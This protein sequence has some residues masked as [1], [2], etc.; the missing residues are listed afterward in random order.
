MPDP[1]M[2]MKKSQIPV[3]VCG[4][5]FHPRRGEAMTTTYLTGTYE[6]TLSLLAETRALLSR[7]PD[8]GRG[9]VGQLRLVREAMRITSRLSQVLAWLM[10]RRAVIEGVISEA[11]SL[12]PERRLS[13]QDVCLAEAEDLGEV[14]AGMK[15]L[16][17]RSRALYE[18]IARLDRMLG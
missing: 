2:A 10:V 9:P 8:G 3:G 11:D 6:E 7:P 18:R 12:A 4:R 14:P 15:R 13:G 16:M 17:E 1:D 5:L